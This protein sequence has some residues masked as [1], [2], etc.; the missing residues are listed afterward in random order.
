MLRQALD[1]VRQLGADH[2]TTLAARANVGNQ[3]GL[4]GDVTGALFDLEITTDRCLAVLGTH[5]RDGRMRA[6]WLDRSGDCAAALAVYER[7]WPHAVSALG[8]EHPT[9]VSIRH[10][11][12]DI[13]EWTDNPG[14]AVRAYSEIKA[15]NA[16]TL[17]PDHPNITAAS[18]S[19][20]Y[21]R[22]QVSDLADMA[23]DIYADEQL[24]GSDNDELS[25]EQRIRVADAVAELIGGF[26][27]E[28][29]GVVELHTILAALTR[30]RGPDD[31]EVLDTRDALAGQ[32]LT[33]G[34]IAG[35]LADC[36]SLISDFTRVYGPTDRRTFRVRR[37]HAFALDHTASGSSARIAALEV[38]L[39]DELSALGPD[40]PVTMQTR[41]YLVG[42]KK[43]AA[44]LR[45]VLIR[46]ACSEPSTQTSP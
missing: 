32:K 1:D 30:E 42:S 25:E 17:G 20:E 2:E 6:Y 8:P 13:R 40:D 34:D 29:D 3:R 28:I 37:H 7:L 19:L 45:A 11:Y 10:S 35:G 5:R 9:T 14:G 15:A 23:H 24:H 27:S 21:W 36:E 39:A 41:M 18:T 33:A 22:T 44:E 31:P 16:R 12:S 38:L 4:A 43:Q 26:D 46:S